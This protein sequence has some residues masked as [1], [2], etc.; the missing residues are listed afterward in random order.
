MLNFKSDIEL[1]VVNAVN[2][3]LNLT[4]T[5]TKDNYK[6]RKKSR[7][8]TTLFMCCQMISKSNRERENHTPIYTYLIH[9]GPEENRPD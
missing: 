5:L 8:K 6:K 3:D 4:S 1:Y 2:F 9:H 7:A